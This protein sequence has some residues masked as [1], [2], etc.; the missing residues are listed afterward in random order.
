MPA[1]KRQHFL[2]A[3]YLKYFSLDQSNC[4]RDSWVWRLDKTGQRQ[5]PVKSQCWNAYHYS[6]NDP[7]AAERGFHRFEKEYCG[8]VDKIRAGKDL[9]DSEY[10]SLLVNMFDFFIRNAIHKNSTGREGIEAYKLRWGMFLQDMVLQRTAKVTPENVQSHIVRYWGLWIASAPQG[11]IF[12][13]SDHPSVWTCIND[14]H[15][16]LHLLSLPLTPTH[17]AIAF[18]KRFLYV[19]GEPMSQD[20]CATFLDS[21]L[22]NAYL[23]AY[24]STPLDAAN[25]DLVK[26]RF[27]DKEDPNDET[28]MRGWRMSLAS[29]PSQYHFSFM[30]LTPPLL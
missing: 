8:C 9:K 5:V 11:R 13:T 14:G 28:D 6:K 2:P 7:A 20:D 27:H 12:I 26:K 18:D 15:P 1:Y 17:M 22:H 4:S 21:Q 23:A 25:L 10:G 29:L 24:S 16:G 3:A 30:R 19:T